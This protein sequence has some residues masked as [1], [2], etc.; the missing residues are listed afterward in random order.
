MTFIPE[1]Y[2]PQGY[3]K[4]ECIELKERVLVWGTET[5]YVGI[6]EIQSG[7]DPEAKQAS[8][9]MIISCTVSWTKYI[10]QSTLF[11]VHS[12]TN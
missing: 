6:K 4:I 11:T 10:V 8:E 9:N 1:R 3:S 12:S 2:L 7:S 5:G